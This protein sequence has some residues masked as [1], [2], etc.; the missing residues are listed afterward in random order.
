MTVVNISFLSAMMNLNFDFQ[1]FS[2]GTKNSYTF[3]PVY[4]CNFCIHLCHSCFHW[5]VSTSK[6]L[7]SIL[8]GIDDG[9]LDISYTE[10]YHLLPVIKI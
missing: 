7:S 8:R 6:F 2:Y 10:L 5:V 4:Q 3:K 9:S 1:T